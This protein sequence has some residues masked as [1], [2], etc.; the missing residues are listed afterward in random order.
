MT[1]ALS[2]GLEP[3]NSL[4]KMLC[5]AKTDVNRPPGKWTLHDR[6]GVIPANGFVIF[7]KT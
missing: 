2:G 6:S 1:L 5:S 3:G 4:G 7:A